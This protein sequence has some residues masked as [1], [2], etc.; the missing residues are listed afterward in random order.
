MSVEQGPS[1]RFNKPKLTAG[2]IVR[3]VNVLNREVESYE[4]SIAHL[5]QATLDQLAFL[6]HAVITQKTEA[7]SIRD[8]IKAKK[9]GTPTLDIDNLMQVGVTEARDLS[10]N[11][12][13]ETADIDTRIDFLRA[14]LHP[15]QQ[16]A[17]DQYLDHLTK[18]YEASTRGFK[19]ANNLNIELKERK[20]T[21]RLSALSEEN[22]DDVI[23]IRRLFMD[24]G[25]D[26][27]MY[28]AYE[29]LQVIE[30]HLLLLAT[31]ELKRRVDVLA[32]YPNFRPAKS[33]VISPLHAYSDSDTV[34]TALPDE[35]SVRQ[36]VP[37]YHASY[38]VQPEKLPDNIQYGSRGVY[39]PQ[40]SRRVDARIVKGQRTQKNRQPS[41]F[42]RMRTRFAAQAAA[43]I[44]LP[45]QILRSIF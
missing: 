38:F 12:R 27:D 1:L 19:R 17:Y 44:S 3:S 18:K 25:I 5:Y 21:H 8:G 15:S 31:G 36:A 9:E 24:S 22:S 13:N 10:A 33:R 42:S 2:D 26:L 41:G 29:Q 6:A 30:E 32:T 11:I 20:A 7:K 37:D 28:G 4:P 40:E 45:S 34:K 39:S 35:P 23:Y 16:R 14:S 43:L